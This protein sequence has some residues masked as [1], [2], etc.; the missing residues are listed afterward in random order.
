[1]SGP[2]EIA[3]FLGRFHPLLVHLPIG[4]IVLLAA[5]ELLARTRRFKQAN[6][7][8]GLILALSIAASTISVVLGLLLSQAGGY[9]SRLLQ[10]HKWTGIATAA[11]C[12][13]A[14]LLYAVDL[15]KPYR[16]C[17]ASAVV[18]L[19][20][21]S[22][23]GGS[24]THGSDYL[25]RYA[26]N[27]IRAWLGGETKTA[28]P[29][30]KTQDLAKL[31]AFAGVIQPVLKEN[32]ISC[33]GPEKSKAGLR[34]DSIEAML[35]GGENGPAIVAGKGA[36][37]PMVKRMLLP[38][39]DQDHM[40]PEGKHQPSADDTALIQW[41]IN[42]GASAKKLVAE[43]KPTAAISRI[44]EARFGAP[45]STSRVAK[46]VPPTPLDQALPLATKLG[47]EL[48]IAITA[49]SP[50]EPWLQCNAGVAGKNFSDSELAKLAQLGPNLRWLDLAGTK[51]SDDGLA[52]LAAMPNLT[53]L[54]LERTAIT[55]A[56]LTNVAN[57]PNLEYLNLYGTEITD[58]GLQTLEK[59][60]KLKQVYLWQTRVTAAAATDFIEARTDKD[61]LQQWQDQIEQLKAKIRDSHIAVDLGTTTTAATSTNA[62]PINSQ[63]PVS[64]KPVD[65]TKTLVHE[66]ALVAFCCDDCKAKFQ[67]DPKPFLTKLAELTTKDSKEKSGQ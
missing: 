50:T 9:E 46:V 28:A 1:M 3:L 58:A 47:D 52:Q 26:P 27:P 6:S 31:Q 36:E 8:A 57:L 12:V 33:H 60:P 25:T 65:P 30:P 21:A 61:Q 43:L 44:L 19:V 59:V 17:L 66:G 29:Q 23:F 63:C 53:R 15:K 40:P 7:N 62:S 20:L 5:L 13:L 34:L 45:A 35:K 56:G 22:H 41:W 4:L 38:G 2:S 24:L 48:S 32:C 51:I 64:G 42:T 18:A 11:V 54:H 10:W 49:L 39:T 14:G 55:D 67:Q 16:W 37:S